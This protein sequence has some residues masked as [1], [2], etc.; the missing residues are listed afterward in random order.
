MREKF[1][2]PEG[3]SKKLERWE[4]EEGLAEYLSSPK[5]K[6]GMH[7]ELRESFELKKSQEPLRRKEIE[8]EAEN[9]VDQNFE[10]FIPMLTEGGNLGKIVDELG[11]TNEQIGLLN[12]DYYIKK[13]ENGE[14]KIFQGD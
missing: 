11:L 1:S 3:Q 4:I 7:P 2:M 5:S 6:E 8:N 13:D 9:F 10:K 12:A 14:T